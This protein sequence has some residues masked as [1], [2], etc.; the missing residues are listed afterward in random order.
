MTDFSPNR[1]VRRL[2]I[3]KSMALN[4]GGGKALLKAEKAFG[5]LINHLPPNEALAVATEKAKTALYRHFDKDGS[6]LYVGV[7][8]N[9]IERTIGHRDNSFWFK[10]IARIEIEWHP[11]RKTAY[12]HEKHAIETECPK[13]NIRD[14][15]RTT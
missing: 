8:L 2:R 10:D 9:A 4:Q 3:A 1:V 12:R 11:S 7:S 14:N 13:Y 6:L 5:K 15:A